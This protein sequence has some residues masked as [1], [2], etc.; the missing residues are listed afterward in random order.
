M[1]DD[2]LED[3]TMKDILKEMPLLICIYCAVRFVA[4]AIEN[5]NN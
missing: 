5:W 2:E 4:F 1:R 3:I